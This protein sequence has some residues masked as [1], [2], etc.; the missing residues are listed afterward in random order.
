MYERI[1]KLKI[2]SAA[3]CIRIQIF[4]ALKKINPDSH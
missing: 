2:E 3:T 1:G 4:Q